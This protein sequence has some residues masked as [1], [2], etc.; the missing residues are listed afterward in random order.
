MKIYSLEENFR[1][2]KFILAAVITDRK[3]YGKTGN[4]R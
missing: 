4:Y 2:D 3:G 1:T